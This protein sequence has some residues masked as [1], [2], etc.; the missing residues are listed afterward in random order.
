MLTDDLLTE[1]LGAAFRD[2]T[3]QLTYAGPVP[4]P[5]RTPLLLVPAAA[6]ATAGIVLATGPLADAPAPTGPTSPTGPAAT[7]GPRLVTATVRVAGYTFT[8]QRRAG[9]PDPLRVRFEQATLPDGVREVAISPPARAW[10]GTDPASGD[11]AV[12]V[13]APTRNEGRLFV[14]LSSTWTRDQLVHLLRTG[15]PHG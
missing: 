2:A 1:E 14:M 4:R 10:V 8:Y 11:A 7:A 13:K 5:R 9:E 15:T 3:A 6:V 12:Y